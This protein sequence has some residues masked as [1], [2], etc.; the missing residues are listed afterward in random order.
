MKMKLAHIVVSLSLSVFIYSC[1]DSIWGN[2]GTVAIKDL[3]TYEQKLRSNVEALEEQNLHL[4]MDAQRLQTDPGR[5]RQEAYKI[6]MLEKGDVK[7]RIPDSPNTAQPISPGTVLT[8]PIIDGSAR[9]LIA[10][11]SISLGFVSLLLITL[12]QFELGL[13]KKTNLARKHQGI[14]VQTASL[15]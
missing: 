14:R 13:A 2:I 5:L 7:L 3:T 8:R 11:V 1:L 6:G 15:E 10:G 9:A 12:L 4:S